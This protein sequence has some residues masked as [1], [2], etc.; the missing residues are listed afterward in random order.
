MCQLFL[1]LRS[2]CCLPHPH[3]EEVKAREQVQGGGRVVF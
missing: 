1:K 2:G 3:T